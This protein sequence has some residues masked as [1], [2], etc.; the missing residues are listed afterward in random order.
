MET[1]KAPDNPTDELK[2]FELSLIWKEAAYNFAFWEQ[3]STKLDWDEAYKEALPAILRTRNLYE[4][5]LELMKFVALLQDGHTNVY[6]PKSV[7]SNPDY[8]SKLPVR[9]IYTNGGYVVSNVKQ[10]AGD[11]VKR[12]SIINKVNGQN[13]QAYVEENI[14]PYIWHEKLDSADYLINDFISNGPLESNMN[15]ELEYDGELSAV[16]LTRTKGDADWLYSGE[17]QMIEDME[18]VYQSDSHKIAM[19]H[20]GI[21][22]ITIDTMMN[23]NLPKEFYA[24]YPLLEKA[25]GYII[26]IRFNGGGNSGNSDAVAAAFIDGEFQNQRSLHPIH[27]G[28]Y[29][30]WSV[31]QD[32]GDK[33]Y[34]EIVAERGESEWL[35]KTYKIPKQ[36]YYEQNISVSQY[37]HNSPGILSAPLVVLTT[38]NTG[39]AAEDLLVIFEHTKRATF[40]GTASFGST[41]QPLNIDLESG[42]SVRICTRH[43]THIDGREFINIGI[44]PHVYFE[45]SMEDLRGGRDVHLE[46]GL[47]VL[48]GMSIA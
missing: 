18:V 5:Y 1:M 24:N 3:L 29:K 21:A 13:I 36:A 28:A 43:N 48:R 33:S 42:G 12:W 7:T 19:T 37:A 41:G 34:D 35:E 6:F 39:S 17:L 11:L 10:A 20:D 2:I 23:N 14:F 22:V 8:M 31:Y 16:T 45:P 15:F 4:Y 25:H 38:A 30:A 27:I 47:K 9:I 46:K 26:D 40:V 32:F 44:E